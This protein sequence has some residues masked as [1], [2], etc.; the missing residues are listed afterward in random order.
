MMCF[1]PVNISARGETIRLEARPSHS[2]LILEHRYGFN[3]AT[4]D[5][6]STSPLSHV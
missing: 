5:S 6:P 2:A 4:P 3:D 1:S